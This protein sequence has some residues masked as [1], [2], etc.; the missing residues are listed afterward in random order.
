MR[1]LSGVLSLCSVELYTCHIRSRSDEEISL[2]ITVV[3]P[4]LRFCS[5]Q[6]GEDSGRLQGLYPIDNGRY[7]AQV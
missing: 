5:A 4:G 1:S 3:L 7:M 2:L 6:S